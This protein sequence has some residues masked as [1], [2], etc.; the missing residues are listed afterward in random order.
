M[1]LLIIYMT[2]A[3][4]V[5]FM[6]S[7]MEAV[8]LSVSPGHLV[9]MERENHPVAPTLRKFKDNIEDPLAESLLSGDFGAGQKIL[10]TRKDEAENLFFTSEAL[11]KDEDGTW[12]WP[13]APERLDLDGPISAAL[14][15]EIASLEQEM[16]AMTTERP[17]LQEEEEES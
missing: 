5:S 6:C 7:I 9:A 8:L 16:A 11:P 3:I 2:V 17:R 15:R 4:G 14:L 10:V 12:Q 1:T 13:F